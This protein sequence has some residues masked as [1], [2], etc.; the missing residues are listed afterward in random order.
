MLLFGSAM[1]LIPE[2]TIPLWAWK[3]SV[4][5]SRAIGAWGVGIGIITLHAS[6]ENDWRRLSPMF[7]SYFTYGLLQL[8]NLLRYPDMINWASPAATL[9][10]I[11]VVSIFIA[12]GYGAWRVKQTQG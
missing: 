2:T 9:Y 1:L 8:I 6:Y 3:L 11:F 5:T 4:L 7:I 10:T 12:G